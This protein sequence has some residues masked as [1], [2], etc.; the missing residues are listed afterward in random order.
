MK[1]SHRKSAKAKRH[2]RQA[3]PFAA[4]DLIQK[5]SEAP[6]D[7]VVQIVAEVRKCYDYLRNSGRSYEKFSIVAGAINVALIRAEKIDP[8]AEETMKLAVEA[9]CNAA[10]RKEKTGH[11]GFNGPELAHMENGLDLY[12]QIFGLSTM[13]QMDEAANEVM[14]RMNKQAKAEGVTL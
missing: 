12:A 8:Q 4:F 9:M 7:K 5:H 1:T 11:Y 3:N 6:N 2:Q 14:R 10:A 13:G